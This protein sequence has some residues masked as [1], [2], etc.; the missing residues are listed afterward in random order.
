M[1]PLK[2]PNDIFIN[3]S[4]CHY[5]IMSLC[6]YVIMSLCSYVIMFLYSFY[7]KINKSSYFVVI[8]AK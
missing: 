5:V 3:M 8:F 7:C 1:F 6:H 4:L 2:S